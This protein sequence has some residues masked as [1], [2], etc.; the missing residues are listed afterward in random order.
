MEGLN[1]IIR[2]RELSQYVGLRRT[3]ISELIAKGEFPRP[4]RL[5]EHGRAKGWL[6][7]EVAL[8][9][10][11]RLAARDSTGGGDGGR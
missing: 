1:R 7:H 2:E 9:Q 5:S 6:Q 4:I 3:Q 10:Q 8:W 11:Q